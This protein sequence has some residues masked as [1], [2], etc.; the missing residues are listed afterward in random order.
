MTKSNHK[1]SCSPAK[2][3]RAVYTREN[4]P[5]LILAAAY[6]RGERNHLYEFGLHKTRTAGV[7]GSLLSPRPDQSNDDVVCFGASERAK[8]RNDCLWSGKSPYFTLSFSFQINISVKFRVRLLR[9]LCGNLIEKFVS[10]Q[11]VEWIKSDVPAMDEGEKMDEISGSLVKQ[12]IFP[13]M[14]RACLGHEGLVYY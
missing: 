1:S 8:K 14:Q 3:H 6:I 2:T 7:N 10:D 5:R 9:N 4:K 11:S 13:P 12:V